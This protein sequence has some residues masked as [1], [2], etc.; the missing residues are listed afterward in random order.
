MDYAL[1][2]AGSSFTVGV[3]KDERDTTS[4]TE[5]ADAPE[6]AHKMAV[7]AE[8]VHKMA[9]TTTP[10]HVSAASHEPSQVPAEC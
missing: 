6:H 4:V 8:P 5:M 3:A 2:C 1:L 9:A 10:R 7:T